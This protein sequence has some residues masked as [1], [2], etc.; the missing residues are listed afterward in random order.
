MLELESTHYTNQITVKKDQSCVCQL[1]YHPTRTAVVNE[2]Y[3][4]NNKPEGNRNVK[5]F[6]QILS[7][8]IKRLTHLKAPLLSCIYM[9]RHSS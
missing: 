6:R 3:I 4:S 9:A 7:Q 2:R 8:C 1:C 5:A